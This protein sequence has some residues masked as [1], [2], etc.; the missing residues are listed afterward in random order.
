VYPN[1]PGN[2]SASFLCTWNP[3]NDACESINGDVNEKDKKSPGEGNSSMVI[4]IVLVAV[5]TAVLLVAVGL[6]I[7]I[8]YRRKA[9]RKAAGKNNSL[10]KNSTEME[11]IDLP[12]S[13]SVV[14]KVRK[15]K[16]GF[17]FKSQVEG[18]RYNLFFLFVYNSDS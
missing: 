10:G 17:I 14:S 16:T 5:I 12:E 8:L 2:V 11:G 3:V 1:L 18:R 15:R 9:K 7:V 4:I 13:S 6:V